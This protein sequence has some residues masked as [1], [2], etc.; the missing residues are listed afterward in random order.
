MSL[1]LKPIK[2]LITASIVLHIA[3][4]LA[5]V[6]VVMLQIPLS[7]MFGFTVRGEILF[8]LPRAIPVARIAIIFTLHIVLG[9]IFYK[10][11]NSNDITQLNTLSILSIIFVTFVAP[12]L[13]NVLQHIETFLMARHGTQYLASQISLRMLMIYGLSIRTLS[14][15][16]L[17]IAASMAFYYCFLV[18][19]GKDLQ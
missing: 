5:V 11:L 6:F 10:P 15:S 13:T 4:L 2:T 9:V 14:L 7:E 18:K 8:V 16:A 12:L 19:S 17:L 1:S 3:S